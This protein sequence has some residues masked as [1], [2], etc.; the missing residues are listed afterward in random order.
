MQ[1][2]RNNPPAV[3]RA[4]GKRCPD[5]CERR[6]V[7]AFYVRPNGQLS[8]YCKDH[9]RERAKASYHRRRQDPAALARMREADRIRKRA[10]RARRKAL[11][12]DREA[13]LARSR[14]SAARRLIA[15]HPEEYR[16]LLAAQGT[17]HGH[18]NQSGSGG[19]SNV[20]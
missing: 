19:D 1:P 13:W 10:S 17:K 7:S 8:A 12:A 15:A 11:G 16:A 18:H 2:N 9:Q 5:C 4:A 6:P 14:E 20:A 3:V